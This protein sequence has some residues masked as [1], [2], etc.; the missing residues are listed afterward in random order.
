MIRGS[1]PMQQAIVESPPPEERTIR[2][3]TSG[4]LNEGTLLPIAPTAS[5]FPFV[6]TGN[7]RWTTRQQEL[8]TR[9]SFIQWV[10]GAAVAGGMPARLL[11]AQDSVPHVRDSADVRGSREHDRPRSAPRGQ[12]VAHLGRFSLAQH[13]AGRQDPPPGR[14]L[15]RQRRQLLRDFRGS[16][17]LGFHS[18][19]GTPAQSDAIHRRRAPSAADRPVRSPLFRS[20]EPSA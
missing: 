8:L 9:R 13:D 4:L 15:R 3:N 7:P 5:R 11:A 6:D 10:G 12:L 16:L 19:V 1:F 17:P 14:C 2:G 20:H 18:A